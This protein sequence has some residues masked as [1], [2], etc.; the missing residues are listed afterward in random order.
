[1]PSFVYTA[2]TTAGERITGSMVAATERDVVASLTNKSLFPISVGLE[3]ASGA[4]LFG[5][6]VSQ[7]RIATFYAQLASLLKN[8]VPLV[9]SLNILRDQASQPVLQNALDDIIKRIEDGEGVSESL[10]RHPRLFSDMAVNMSRAG[11][12]GGFLEDALERVAAFT[13]HQA[14]LRAKTIG[15]LIYPVILATFGI[16]I[17]TLLLVFVV[18]RFE[19]MFEQMRQRDSMPALTEWL[20]AFSGW[21]SRRGWIVGLL[22]VGLVIVARIQLRT[23]AGK[24]TADRWRLKI[25][26]FGPIFRNLA[27]ARF[28]RVLGTLLKNGVPILKSLEISRQAAGNRVLS[29]A[30]AQATENISS[31][32]TLAQPLTACGLFPRNVTEMIAVAEESNS[33]DSVLVNI[34]DGLEKETSRRLELMVRMVEPL[35]LLVMAVGVLIIVMSL[36]MPIMNMNSTMRAG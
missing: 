1:M 20:L 12:E 31:G 2:R 4:P 16:A 22:L 21:M 18:P 15:A 32:E 33:L 35:M 5:G 19:P 28:C 6:R 23:D 25:P 7:Q 10:A 27:V 3:K 36:L 9:R 30:I 26:L 8:G 29:D 13:E 24:L 17:M 14:E 34:S 11:A